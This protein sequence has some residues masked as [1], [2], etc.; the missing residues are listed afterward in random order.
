M[1]SLEVCQSDSC[2]LCVI[3]YW[4]LLSLVVLVWDLIMHH[5]YENYAFVASNMCD[6]EEPD[7]FYETFNSEKWMATM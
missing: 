7:S 3:V 2:R 4:L 1:R 6:E 5:T